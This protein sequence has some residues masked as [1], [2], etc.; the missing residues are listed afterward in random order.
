MKP[1]IPLRALLAFALVGSTGACAVPLAVTGASY[2]AD[3][4]LLLAS[5]KTSADHLISMVS[6][7]DC[8]LWRAVR[9]R[10]VCRPR[11]GDSDPYKVDYASAERVVS[12]DGV[13]YVAP[14]RPAEDAPAAS[15]DAAAY[16]QAAP[17]SPEPPSPDKAAPSST[18]VA[19]AAAAAAPAPQA[20]AEPVA[21]PPAAAVPVPPRPKKAKVR[22]VRKP[23]RGRAASGS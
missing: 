15:W 19:N 4:G 16:G 18:A 10:V 11:E 12:E 6:K 21:E 13:R 22:S 3:G 17:S 14:L 23:S 9:G 2:A 8:A 1:S 7:Q 20:T 5:D